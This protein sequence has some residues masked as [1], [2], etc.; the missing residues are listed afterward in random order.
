MWVRIHNVFNILPL[1]FLVFCAEMTSQSSLCLPLYGVMHS[2]HKITVHGFTMIL[3]YN[4]T[5]HVSVITMG[6]I[7]Y[8]NKLVRLKKYSIFWLP[9]I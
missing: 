1:I 3:L 2:C 6:K 5:L 4:D 8:Y 7:V 9:D